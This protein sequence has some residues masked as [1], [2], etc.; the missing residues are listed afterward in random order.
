MVENS[1]LNAIWVFSINGI[2]FSIWL[3]GDVNFL[4]GCNT[5]QFQFHHLSGHPIFG[6]VPDL[7]GQVDSWTSVESHCFELSTFVRNK[8]LRIG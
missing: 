7:F 5:F 2:R 8:I 3:K 4:V 6:K 1:N